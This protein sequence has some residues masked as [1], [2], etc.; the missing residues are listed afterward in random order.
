MTTVSDAI[1]KWSWWIMG[2]Q[3]GF[4]IIIGFAVG[5]VARK[6][7]RFSEERYYFFE[8]LYLFLLTSTITITR[9]WIDKESF[10]VYAIALS[11][12]HK[13]IP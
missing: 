5:Y 9:K 7:L 13:N 11:V 8:N 4:S 12:S 6:T 1:I 3:I 10:L 2:Y